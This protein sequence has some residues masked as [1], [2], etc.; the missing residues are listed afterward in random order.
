MQGPLAVLR[1]VGGEIVPIRALGARQR[2]QWGL[3]QRR[4]SPLRQASDRAM[5]DQV[6]TLD[7]IIDGDEA[8]PGAA[9]RPS[10]RRLPRSRPC[11]ACPVTRLPVAAEFRGMDAE[12]FRR[13]ADVLQ[14]DG[15]VRWA[16][17]PRSDPPPSQ[18][19][20]VATPVR[21]RCFLQAR[22]RASSSLALREAAAAPPH[23]M[24]T[25]RAV[26][27]PP[28]SALALPAYPRSRVPAAGRGCRSG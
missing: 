19:S 16:P 10:G 27:R 13:V 1:G 12:V 6:F 7:E 9:T 15:R 22:A 8:P 21:P 26:G 25:C 14:G 5:I 11:L 17:P 28:T 18:S 23:G 4:P 3:I 20:P 24:S 2:A